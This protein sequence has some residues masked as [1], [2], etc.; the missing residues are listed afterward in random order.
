MGVVK[1]DSFQLLR[2]QTEVFT[3]EITEDV[4]QKYKNSFSA[5]PNCKTLG[6]IP[7]CSSMFM[8]AVFTTGIEWKHP[9]VPP[10]YEWIMKKMTHLHS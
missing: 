5:W 4:P 1:Q 3:R 6:H 10:T 7:I 9:S 8:D 2:V